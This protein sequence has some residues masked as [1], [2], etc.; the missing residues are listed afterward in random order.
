MTLPPASGGTR[1]KLSPWLLKKIF[2]G[3]DVPSLSWYTIREGTIVPS[4][5]FCSCPPPWRAQIGFCHPGR[6]TTFSHPARVTTL[7][8]GHRLPACKIAKCVTLAAGGQRNCLILLLAQK[9]HPGSSQGGDKQMSPPWLEICC[10]PSARVTKR[11]FV[12]SLARG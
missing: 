5:I 9:K 1:A 10:P 4:L 6:M 3:G 12:P 11:K 8:G 2:R 7:E